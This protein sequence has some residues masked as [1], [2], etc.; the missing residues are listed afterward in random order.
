MAPLK[1]YRTDPVEGDVEARDHYLYDMLRNQPN[2]ETTAY[3]FMTWFVLDMYLT[4]GAAVILRNPDSGQVESVVQIRGDKVVPC[5][6]PE[7]TLFYHYTDDDG[8]EWRIPKESMLIAKMF[9]DKGSLGSAILDWQKDTFQHG[10]KI[11]NFSSG[12][13]DN[14]GILSGVVELPDDFDDKLRPKLEEDFRNRY[15]GSGNSYGVPFLPVGAK[16]EMLTPNPVDSQ[17]LESSKHFRS[18]VNGIFRVP[19]HL[20][21]DLEK[22]TFS[23]IEHIGMQYVTHTLLPIATN[24][25]QRY[26][27]TF[28]TRQERQE[29]YGFR[30]DLS[31]FERGDLKT[32]VEAA[33]LAFNGALK[34]ANENRKDF[35]LPR[36]EG[37][38]QLFFNST[39]QPIIAK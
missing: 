23:N 8:E 1:L 35:N 7:G 12:F 34:S 18:I 21:N 24:I 2:S 15:M 37:G 19:A 26:R 3:E 27:M 30:F 33:S 16:F 6:T 31:A 9:Y 36:K 17:M 4:R 32:R 10:K 28:L 39:L 29:G 11:S 13:F 5:R 25:Q 14:S 38:D 22:A 20:S